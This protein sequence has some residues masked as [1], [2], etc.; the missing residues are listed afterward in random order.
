[1][2]APERTSLPQIV[3]AATALL[4]ASGVEALTMQ[5]VAAE[6]GVRAPSLY[7][8]VRGRDA[9]LALVAEGIARELGATLELAAGGAETGRRRLV[10]LAN[11]VREFAR[12]R[13]EAYSLL[14]ARLPDAARPDPAVLAGSVAVVLRVA[15]DAVGP[16]RALDAARLLTAWVHGFVSMELAD[17]FRMG[18][19]LDRAFAFGADRLADALGL[20]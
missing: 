2:P 11:A 8:R 12:E 14:F 16:E 5:A 6:V 3:A 20:E 9:L 7:K 18:D 13:P 17:R 1:M 19:E 4:E 10:A 15:A